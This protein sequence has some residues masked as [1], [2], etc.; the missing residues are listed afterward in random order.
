MNNNNN[1]NMLTDYNV[2]DEQGTLKW[3]RDRFGMFTSSRCGVLLQQNKE[4]NGFGEKAWGYIREILRDRRLDENI[5]KDDEQFSL[6]LKRLRKSNFAMDYGSEMEVLSNDL[7]AEKMNVDITKV[8]FIKK[9]YYYGGSPDGICFAKLPKSNLKKIGKPLFIVEYKNPT[10]DTYNDYL[11]RL[12][13][14]SDVK[15]LETSSGY[16]NCYYSQV[17]LNIHICNVDY[18][19]LEITDYMFKKK[20]II[21]KIEKDVDH[22]ERL[23]EKIRDANEWVEKKLKED[24]L[25]EK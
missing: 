19:Y 16:R 20:K 24:K 4:K 9:T 3:H 12:F 23:I 7:F 13:T 8:G 15:K 21:I 11:D 17:Q 14:S 18:G 22:I 25:K 1:N 5:V 2:G 10:P 6:Y